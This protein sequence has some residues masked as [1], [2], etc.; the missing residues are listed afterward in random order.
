ML[1]IVSKTLYKALGEVSKF[2]CFNPT[3]TFPLPVL[4]HFC[5]TLSEITQKHCSG[6][7]TRD[8]IHVR[9]TA[10]LRKDDTLNSKGIKILSHVK[11]CGRRNIWKR[12]G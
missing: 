2:N 6:A 9:D 12:T 3:I 11:G 7:N 5:E 10:S 8:I 4:P 1:K